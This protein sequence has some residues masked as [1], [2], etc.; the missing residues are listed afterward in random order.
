MR[1]HDDDDKDQTLSELARHHD[2]PIIDLLLEIQEHQ[3][4]RGKDL[5][6]LQNLECFYPKSNRKRKRASLAEHFDDDESEPH[7][8]LFR[9]DPVNAYNEPN[10][11][12]I[13]WCWTLPGEKGAGKLSNAYALET[14]D[15]QWVR[16]R[17][18]DRIFDRVVRYMQ[19]FDVE[20]FWIDKYSIPQRACEV[21]FDCDHD[22]CIRKRESLQAMDLVYKHSRHPVGLLEQQLENEED[23]ALLALLLDG[24]MVGQAPRA[25][26]FWLPKGSDTRAAK[27]TLKLV[28][29]LTSD[30][31]WK[32]AW[33]FQENY[34]GGAGM[35]L[36]L[37]H[38]HHLEKT[39]RAHGNF[40][41]VFGELCINSV[42]F[43][44][45]AT[46]LCLAL[47]GSK[48]LESEEKDAITQILSA[49]GRY[50]ILLRGSS[51][52]SPSIV[53]NI[54]QRDV[55]NVWD[56]IAIVANCCK[57]S[58]RLDE[59]SLKEQ[60]FS[61]SLSMLTMFLLNGEIL[62]ND[63]F[64]MDK[65]FERYTV[66][67]LLNM[68]SFKGFHYPANKYSLTFNKG[69]RFTNVELKEDGILTKG[70]LWKLGP[71]IDTS[72]FPG[73]IPQIDNPYG[74]LSLHERR[75]LLQLTNEL[76][77]LSHKYLADQLDLFLK[78]DA[79]SFTNEDL[80]RSSFS[81]DYMRR[82][83]VEIVASIVEG[84]ILRLGHLSTSSRSGSA[85]S[86]IFTWGNDSCEPLRVDSHSIK[87]IPIQRVIPYVFTASW[88]RENGWEEYDANDIDRHVSLEVM[89]MEGHEEQDQ[90]PRL[91]TRRW[92]PGLCFFRGC[93]RE[94]VLFPWPPGLKDMKPDA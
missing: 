24:G 49:A 94:D 78:Q 38:S 67:Q 39:K 46:R 79:E 72:T 5:R 70:H 20:L 56:R 37:G 62:Y 69:C 22:R 29:R 2:K 11:V 45:E 35:T 87:H 76:R 57:Y 73:N 74:I 60:G 93:P 18:R 86:A 68:Q 31:W 42:D 91:Y 14:R 59:L 64:E 84:K 7:T 6:F 50:T 13:S 23:L 71:I 9:S 54:E 80:T 63:P 40:G 27:K 25:Q 41:D 16:P 34:R 85:Y 81:Q 75:R 15:G 44:Y 53:S 8:S 26:R 47:K 52:M 65:H 88:P 30:V 92:R 83:A 58:I 66:S 89:Q 3:E 28:Q 32:R 48:G 36:L 21:A 51:S 90:L 1:G 61:L 19:N 12:A 10:Y 77:L 17:L 4:R 55:G 33:I 43:S 82:M